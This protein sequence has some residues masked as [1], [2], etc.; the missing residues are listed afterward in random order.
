[1]PGRSAAA[2]MASQ[3][4]HIVNHDDGRTQPARAPFYIIASFRKAASTEFGSAAALGIRL[5]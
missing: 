1:M 4:S 3:A 5:P 2:G